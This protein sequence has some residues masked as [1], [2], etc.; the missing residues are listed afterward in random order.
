MKQ[1]SRARAD[2]VPPPSEP[3]RLTPWLATSTERN[4]SH[5]A[6]GLADSAPPNLSLGD[7]VISAMLHWMAN[8]QGVAESLSS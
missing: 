6:K 5:R 7:S 4:G 2:V 8:I 3:R 1:E